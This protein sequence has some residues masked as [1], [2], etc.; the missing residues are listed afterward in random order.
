MLPTQDKDFTLEAPV[1]AVSLELSKGSWKM[2]LQDGK[3][4]K[5]A[6]HTVSSEEADKR[7]REAIAVIE[8]MKR[9]WNLDAGTR[10]VV[11][12]EA[13]QDGFWISRA[14]NKLG[15]EAQCAIAEGMIANW[16][17]KPW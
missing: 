17:T 8:E 16:A 9:K 3:R 14:L 1:L 6:I 15:Y 12:Y 5:P 2:A 7:L 13:G 10:V 4:D 11:M